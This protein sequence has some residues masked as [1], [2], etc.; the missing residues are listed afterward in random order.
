[1]PWRYSKSDVA[2]I[3]APIKG[4]PQMDQKTWEKYRGYYSHI[5]DAERIT[6]EFTTVAAFLEAISVMFNDV[7]VDVLDLKNRLDS[8]K[9]NP[10]DSGGYLD[11]MVNGRFKGSRHIFEVQFTLKAFSNF[12]K[13][14]VDSELRTMFRFCVSSRRVP[15]NKKNAIKSGESEV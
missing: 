8:T 10:E 4:M 1:M 12:G 15:S 2:I 9:W 13:S 7:G 6:M 5:K 11:V 14:Y 3:Q